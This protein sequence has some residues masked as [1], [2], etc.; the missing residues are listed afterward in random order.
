M[1]TAVARA[2]ACTLGL[3]IGSSACASTPSG[4]AANGGQDAAAPTFNG[5]T[6]PMFQNG[7]RAS[8]VSFGGA[9]GSPLFGYAPP[10]L[11][12]AAGASVT[13]AGDFSVHPLSPGTSPTT[14][15]AGSAN[16]PIAR[17]ET[18][19]SLAVTF[20]TAGVYPYFCEMHYAAGMAGVVL[21]TAP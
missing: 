20:P 12:V 21:V 10:C 16:N 3:A 9:G 8:T 17:T 19:T 15:T 13:F 11:R 18:G 6:P 1:I 5:C 2:A 4:S 14:T 7:P